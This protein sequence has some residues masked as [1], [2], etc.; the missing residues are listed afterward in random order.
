[1]VTF[2]AL[3]LAVVCSAN[4]PTQLKEMIMAEMATG[5]NYS[6]YNYASEMT[7]LTIASEMILKAC[8]L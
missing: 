7:L 1:M 2:G 5:I 8:L 4:C 3:Y 6:Y